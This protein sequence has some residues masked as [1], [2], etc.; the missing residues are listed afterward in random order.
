[1]KRA[2][3]GGSCVG[4]GPVLDQHPIFEESGPLCEGTSPTTAS[5]PSKVGLIVP[6][7]ADGHETG[8]E[9]RLMNGHETIHK[10]G[11]ET[12]YETGHETAGVCSFLDNLEWLLEHKAPALERQQKALEAELIETSEENS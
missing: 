8:H 5:G 2:W 6:N 7:M 1:M 11:H 12:G 3:T 10:N 4:A 9:T